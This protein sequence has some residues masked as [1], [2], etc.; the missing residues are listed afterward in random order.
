MDKSLNL[1]GFD[2]GSKRIGV[3]C[4]NQQR[5]RGSALE[6]I[7]API[8][9]RAWA[10]GFGEHSRNRRAFWKDHERHIVS[11]AVSCRRVS[12]GYSNPGERGKLGH[13]GGL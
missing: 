8:H 10:F 11:T 4:I 12:G 3:A 13:F 5:A 7:S 6:R 1:L 9:R 2:F